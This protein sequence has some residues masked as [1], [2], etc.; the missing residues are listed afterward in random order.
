MIIPLRPLLVR[1]GVSILCLSP[2]VLV[3][4]CQKPTAKVSGMVILDGE[5]LKGGGT[6]TFQLA[7]Q[8]GV[9][10]II[11]REGVYTLRN[12]PVGTVKI[13]LGSGMRRSAGAGG[14]P[15][16]PPPKKE[17]KR[18]STHEPGPLNNIP[19]KY[20]DPEASEL[21]YTVKPGEQTFDII[22]SSE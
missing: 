17:L 12:V 18:E 9:S 22:L 8:G 6:V 19:Q 2:L 11:T 14:M 4:G 16:G 5:A 7:G 15:V 13:T 1:Y 3:A 21:T 20:T 10:G